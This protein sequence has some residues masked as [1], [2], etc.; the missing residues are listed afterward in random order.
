M[1]FGIGFLVLWKSSLGFDREFT[2]SVGHLGWHW[3][4]RECSLKFTWTPRCSDGIKRCGLGVTGHE[5]GLGVGSA[6][7]ERPRFRT[8]RPAVRTQPRPPQ[9]R[10]PCWCPGLG[11]PASAV[12]ARVCEGHLP[13]ALCG[14]SAGGGDLAQSEASPAPHRLRVS[15]L[16]A[17]LAMFLLSV[18]ASAAAP[19][20]WRGAAVP[21]P[22]LPCHTLSPDGPL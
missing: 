21:W 7:W 13:A 22:A 16:G 3:L 1:N 4:W 12:R 15:L 20:S 8:P 9:T 5:S 17:G 18:V 14:H 11:L 6:P 10:P 2:E 19:S